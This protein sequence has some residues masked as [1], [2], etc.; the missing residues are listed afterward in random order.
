MTLRTKLILITTV[1]VALL[2]GVSEWL[3]YRHITALLDQHETILRETT[4]HAVAL[5]RLRVT[6]DQAL[7]SATSIRILHAVGTLVLAVAILNLI[8]YRVIYRP[9]R[10]LLSHMNIVGRGAW[11]HTLP[12]ERQD[13]IGE[14]TAA[15]ND[16]GQQLT[17]TFQHI[18]SSSKLSAMALIGGRL[19]RELTTVRTRIAGSAR[20]LNNRKD[21]R[22]SAVAAELAGI[23]EQLAA[24]ETA[25]QSDFEQELIAM[26][27][28]T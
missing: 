11:T 6:R 20:V 27:A 7:L 2:F 12:V 28:K 10:Q 9:I 4:D 18:N 24:L 17:S 22:M 16:L 21:T 25:L 13:E 19:G 23:D 3:S 14:L 15:F 5:E 26:R 8:W 1:V